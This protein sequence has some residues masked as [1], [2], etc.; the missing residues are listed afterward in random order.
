MPGTMEGKTVVI[1]G[2]TSGIGES[3]AGTLA[4]MGARI[5][6][7][8]RDPGKG[9][10]MLERLRS[11]N[12]AAAHDW[13][14][15]D[16]STLAAMKAAGAALAEK[17]P[18]IDV[19]ANNAGAMFDVRHETADGL[20]LTFALNHMAYFVLTQILRPNLAAGARIVSTSSAAHVAGSIDFDD[21]QSTRRYS[22][23][24]VYG[25]SKL[26]NILFTRALARRLEGSGV[27]ANCLHPGGV[28]TSFGSNLK[29]GMRFV[30]GLL[31]PLFL[32]PAQG[33]DTLVYLASSDAVAGKSGGYYA[34]RRL[35]TPSAAARDDAAAERLWQVSADLAGLPA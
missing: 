6:F 8:A 30:F 19:L 21:L 16:L 2:A 11:I 12:P 15:A 22:T 1:T 35:T 7:V 9:S 4:G 33:A 18:R 14:E 17:A 31:K 32:T 28:S 24:G 3:A 13:V 34:K 23:L 10:A 27:T 25:A 20:E 26:C 29:P 5:V